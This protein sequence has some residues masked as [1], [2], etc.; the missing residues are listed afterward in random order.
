MTDKERERYNV[1]KATFESWPEWKKQAALAFMEKY[2]DV[3]EKPMRDPN[4]IPEFMDELERAWCQVPDWRFGQLIVNVL[5][6]DPFYIEDD[7]ALD[8]FKAMK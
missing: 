5:G 3:E 7:K 8:A 4:R 1:C 2:K 6:I